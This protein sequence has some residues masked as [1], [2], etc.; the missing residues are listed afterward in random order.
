MAHTIK[1]VICFKF[2]MRKKVLEE[3]YNT[4]HLNRIFKTFI[5]IIKEVIVEINEKKNHD[6]KSL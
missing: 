4:L 6:S 1:N 5:W 2:K 3:K